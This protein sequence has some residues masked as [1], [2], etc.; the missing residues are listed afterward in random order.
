MLL[1]S[2]QSEWNFNLHDKKIFLGIFQEKGLP[3][4]DRKHFPPSKNLLDDPSVW[5]IS[6]PHP[7]DSGKCFTYK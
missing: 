5:T 3:Y 1:S 6:I 7:Q 4:C 2:D